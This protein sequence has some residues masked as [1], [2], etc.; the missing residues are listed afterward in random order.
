[1]QF[2]SIQEIRFRLTVLWTFITATHIGHSFRGKIVMPS[3]CFTT[4]TASDEKFALKANSTHFPSMRM[5][6][7][8]KQLTI[9]NLSMQLR[10]FFRSFWILFVVPASK[11]QSNS[12]QYK[13][14]RIGLSFLKCSISVQK[15]YFCRAANVTDAEASGDAKIWNRDENRVDI[16]GYS[17]SHII[18]G[19][20][21]RAFTICVER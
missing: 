13:S 12:E 15:V 9:G 3:I 14:D 6:S 8:L 4:T 11:D 16:I 5:V 20:N 18:K 17:V 21:Y 1:M 2:H 19:D 7:W 10:N